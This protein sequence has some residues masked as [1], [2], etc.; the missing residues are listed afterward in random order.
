[1]W[2]HA[3]GDENGAQWR[4]EPPT[5]DELREWCQD[6][7]PLALR[8]ETRT[9]I[10]SAPEHDRSFDQFLVEI[11]LARSDEDNAGF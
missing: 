4:N 8:V 2:T 5:E 10:E 3:T 9:L 11:H 6:F 1:M 7:Q